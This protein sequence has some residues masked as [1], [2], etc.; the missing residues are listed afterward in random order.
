MIWGP[1][2]GRVLAKHG[3]RPCL[4]LGGAALA[5]AGVLLGFVT[6]VTPIWYLLIAY[7]AVGLGN[8]SVGAPITTTAV[9]GMPPAQS[10]VAAGV[11]STTR[12]VGQTLGVAIAGVAIA[13][14][15]LSHVHQLAAATHTDWWLIAAYGTTVF[16]LGI[17]STTRW[18]KATAEKALPSAPVGGQAVLSTSAVAVVSKWMSASVTI[19]SHPTE[20]RSAAADS[21]GAREPHRRRNATTIR[22]PS[23]R[24]TR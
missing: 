8:V 15:P 10:S 23:G 1:L 13:S 12:Q 22:P 11:S 9:A 14:V 7:A 3:P 19:G 20:R 6:T 4:M 18:A 17:V 2:N 16:L 5:V 21:G 24:S